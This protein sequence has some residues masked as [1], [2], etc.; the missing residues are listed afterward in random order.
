MNR[1]Y[2][3]YG[4]DTIDAMDKTIISLWGTYYINEVKKIE[5]IKND[6]IRKKK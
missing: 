1:T 5:G 6:T 3:V 4:D 2:N